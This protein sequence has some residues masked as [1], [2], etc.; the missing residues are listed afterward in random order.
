MVWL[1]I[2]PGRANPLPGS[3]GTADRERALVHFIPEAR[4]PAGTAGGVQL[5]RA[6][7][8]LRVAATDA[9]SEDDSVA[10]GDRLAADLDVRQRHVV[11]AVAP[12]GTSASPTVALPG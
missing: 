7:E 8:F 3:A 2:R 10:A 5:H 6:E 1:H 4:R 12:C 11:S 9:Q